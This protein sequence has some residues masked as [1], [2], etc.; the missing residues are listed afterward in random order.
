MVTRNLIL[1]QLRRLHWFA[2]RDPVENEL[3]GW[4][5]D[6]PPLRPR[7]YLGLGVSEVSSKYCSTRRDIWLRRVMGTK[8]SASI[9]EQ[10][11]IGRVVHEVFRI[12]TSE[13]RKLVVR[14]LPGWEVYERLACKCKRT[15]SCNGL[16]PEPWVIDL[17]KTLLLMF[18]A[19]SE[20][21]NILHGAS[22]SIGWLPYVSEFKVDGSMLG[23]SSNLSVDAIAEGGVIVEIKYGRPMDFHK[24]ALTGYALALEANLEVPF[25]YGILLHINGL[26]KSRPRIGVEPVYISS[27]LRREFIDERDEIIDM[28]LS[29]REPPK[30]EY[31]PYLCPYREV[32]LQ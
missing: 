21:S 13:V 22:P 20:S 28:V 17:Y 1:K 23:L 8:P 30:P 2:S 5:W 7:A 29:G 14:D 31:C 10:L 24:L 15:L 11:C 27:S 25:D 3:R 18:T 19:E 12:V 4:N 26:P 16:N 9:P 6:K 32:C